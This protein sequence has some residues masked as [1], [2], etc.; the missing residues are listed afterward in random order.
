MSNLPGI[1]NGVP[2]NFALRYWPFGLEQRPHLYTLHHGPSLQR[3]SL[4]DP[5]TVL[6]NRTL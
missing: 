3:V 6:E 2:R 4:A 5:P 1:R